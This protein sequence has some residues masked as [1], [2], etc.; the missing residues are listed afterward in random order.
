VQEN[1]KKNREQLSQNRGTKKS[2]KIKRFSIEDIKNFLDELDSNKAIDADLLLEG[3]LKTFDKSEVDEPL[4]AISRGAYIFGSY[5]AVKAVLLNVYGR[6]NFEKNYE[7][8]VESKLEPMSYEDDM[9]GFTS[10]EETPKKS[11]VKSSAKSSSKKSSKK[12][13]TQRKGR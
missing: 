2:S 11:E 6:R 1:Q 4:I 9:E 13:M 7:K 8:E 12:I 3:K 10:G 5:E